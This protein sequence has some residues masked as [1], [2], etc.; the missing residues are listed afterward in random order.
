MVP[1]IGCKL[2]REERT[3]YQLLMLARL[4]KDCLNRPTIQEITRGVAIITRK[5]KIQQPGIHGLHQLS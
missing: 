1:G 3:R 2:I 4:S 5:R